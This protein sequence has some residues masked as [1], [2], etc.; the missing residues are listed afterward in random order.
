MGH[1]LL[2][3]SEM[4]GRVNIMCELARRLEAAGHTVAIA[5]PVDVRR[6]VEAQGA[7]YVDIAPPAPVPGVPPG[8][9]T[10]RRMGQFLRR[11]G[12]FLRRLGEVRTVGRRRRSKADATGYIEMERAI[13]AEQPDV[14]LVDI[15][16]PSQIMAAARSQTSLALWTSLLSLWKRP[17]LP[18]LGSPIEP[19]VG[20]TGSRAGIEWAWLRFRAWK[21][22]RSQRLRVTRVGEDQISVLRTV[23]GLTGFPF[24]TETDRH[25]WLIP[26]TYRT[27]PTVTFNA[28]ELELP[29]DPP[30]ML[31]YA[32]PVIPT[33]AGRDH[34]DVDQESNRVR[35]EEL[36]A[37]RRGGQSTALV[38]CSFGAWHKGDDRA[39]L[40]RVFDAVGSHPEWDAVVGLGGRIEPVALGPLPPNVHVF[41]WA[42]QLEILRNADCA[43]H[44]GGISTVNECIVNGVPMLVYPFDFMDQ[45]GN[46]ARVAFHGLGEFG[47]RARDTAAAI[48]GRI[49]RLLGDPGVA[50]RM[51]AMQS[52][53][54][55]YHAAGR[56]IEFVE[57]VMSGGKP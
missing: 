54:E 26:F 23:A 10:H 28:V 11:L 46:A 32:G 41:A 47:D 4:A 2:V 9:E 31:T 29:H 43:V 35:L 55:I 14:T 38:Y 25:Q 51:A 45:P 57:R 21:W 22:L 42:P 52:A 53:F 6:R 30:P 5:C 50:A 34:P 18:P 27:L 17:G 39:F 13:A 44:H 20:W 8:P 16:L 36:F 7:R 33:S 37:R 19:G 1:V 56:P 3:T 48:A 12:E 15:E 49:S 24:R 40:G